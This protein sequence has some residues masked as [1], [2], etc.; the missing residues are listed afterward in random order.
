MSL[1]NIMAE[2]HDTCTFKIE[3]LGEDKD[4]IAFGIGPYDF[5]FNTMPNAD[6]L[7]YKSDTGK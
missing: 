2:E 7:F 1:H 6:S 4:A 5:D 3:E